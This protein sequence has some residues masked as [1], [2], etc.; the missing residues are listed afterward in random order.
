L[1][2]QLRQK[3]NGASGTG[4]ELKKEQKFQEK[5]QK[6]KSQDPIPEPMEIQVERLVRISL[7]R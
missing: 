2:Q 3:K 1:P 6:E 7:L 4:T 5:P